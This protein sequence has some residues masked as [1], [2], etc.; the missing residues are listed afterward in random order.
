[1]KSA[2][3]NHSFKEFYELGQANK[4]EYLLDYLEAIQ[5][6]LYY[7]YHDMILHG[8][9][10]NELA[11]KKKLKLL[12]CINGEVNSNLS[13]CIKERFTLDGLKLTYEEYISLEDD[14]S[15]SIN[16]TFEQTLN[17][18]YKRFFTDETGININTNLLQ[19][20]I[21]KHHSLWPSA[22]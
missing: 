22:P 2:L 12:D 14:I 10:E 20:E 16:D 3:T 17:R 15:V 1:M 13:E 7:E 19:Q 9:N 11:L 21:L 5:S 18:D 6:K 8:P 4:I